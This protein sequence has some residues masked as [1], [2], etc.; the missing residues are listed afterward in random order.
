MAIGIGGRGCDARD[1]H[2]SSAWGRSGE[3]D[4]DVA[5]LFQL[6]LLFKY[7]ARRSS[8]AGFLPG[9]AVTSS[10]E[11]VWVM[12]KRGGSIGSSACL[13]PPLS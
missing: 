12:R 10:N 4:K 8:P 2:A 3:E 11:R 6:R 5:Q 1:A 13:K 9:H 7:D